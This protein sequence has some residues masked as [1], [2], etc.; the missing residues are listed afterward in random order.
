MPKTYHPIATTTVG[1]ATNLISFSSIPATYTD[2]RLVLA[3]N[4]AVSQYANITL[5]G[6]SGSNYSYVWMDGSGS[7]TASGRGSNDTLI[8]LSQ[9]TTPSGTNALFTLNFLSYTASTFKTILTVNNQDTYV[10]NQVALWR[11]TS[12]INQINLNSGANIYGIG[13]TATLYGIKAA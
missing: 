3:L 12:A 9:R 6:D 1:T 11:S 7:A 10:G 13:T 2:L 5:N 8:Y 4:S